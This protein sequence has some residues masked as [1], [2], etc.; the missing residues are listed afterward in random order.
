MTYY[1][2]LLF[3]VWFV[4]KRYEEEQLGPHDEWLHYRSRVDCCIQFYALIL[5]QLVKLKNNLHI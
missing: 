1:I 5:K 4:R 2:V 3:T